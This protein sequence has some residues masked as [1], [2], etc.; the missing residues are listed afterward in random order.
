MKRVQSLIP[1][2]PALILLLVLP[3]TVLAETKTFNL[4]KDTYAN[5]AYPDQ[6]RGTTGSVVISN[7]FTTRLGYLQFEDLDFPEG[8]IIDQGI[9]KLYVYELH[10]AETAKVNVGPVTGNWEENTL[11]WNAKP[12][13]NQT[14]AIEAEVSL[15][16]AGWKEIS[17]TNLTKQWFEGTIEN[18]GLFIYPYG[19]LYSTPETEYAFTFKSKESGDQAAKLEVEYHL[20]PSPEPSPEESAEPSPESETSPS[21]STEEVIN[22]EATPEPSP[23]ES[24][25]PE[26]EEGSGKVLGLFSTGQALIAL[27][28]LLALAGAIISF[29]GYARKPKEKKKKKP[30]KEEEPIE[31]ENSEEE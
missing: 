11:T 16:S 28:I 18:K 26:A 12:T 24:P 29:I 3:K 30:K 5:Q 22:E 2:L 13:I 9:L 19:F 1:L 4:T 15:T 10:Y 27:L 14:Q 8:A 17:I 7:K 21:P 20:E 25:S 23:E 31:E 6:N